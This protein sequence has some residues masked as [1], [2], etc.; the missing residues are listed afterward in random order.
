MHWAE[1]QSITT[2]LFSKYEKQ[3]QVFIV[4]FGISTHW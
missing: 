2:Q 4:V 1:G 3:V